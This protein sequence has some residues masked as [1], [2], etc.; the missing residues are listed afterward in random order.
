MAEIMLL[1]AKS[2]LGKIAS[3]TGDLI[4]S[5]V[6]KEMKAVMSV[7]KDVEN[8][9]N[10]LEAICAVLEDADERQYV[11]NAFHIWIRNLKRVVYDIDD[12]LDE[13]AFD[14]LKHRVN[15]SHLSSLL[16][17]I[18]P[19]S[20]LLFSLQ[21]SHKIRDLRENLENIVA[22]RNEFGLTEHL[23]ERSADEDNWSTFNRVPVVNRPDIVGRC[24]AEKEILEK[25]GAVRKYDNLY[26]LPIVGMGGIGKTVLAKL[27]YCDVKHFDVKVWVSVSEKFDMNKIIKGILEYSH[28]R[29]CC[30]VSNNVEMGLR[31]VNKFLSRKKYFL[32][33]DDVWEDKIDEW[34]KLRNILAVG[35]KGS[36]VLVTTRKRQV[37][38]ITKTVDTYYLDCLPN[39]V[40]WD[41]FKQ[42][43][44]EKDEEKR[45]PNLHGIGLSIVE[46]CHGVPTVVKSLGK[47]LRNERDNQE[48]HRIAQM[49]NFIE[50]IHQ[51]DV[52][53]LKTLEISYHK[54][55]SHLKLCFAYLSLCFKGTDLKTNYVSY[56]WS[57]LGLLPQNEDIEL[58]GY[59]YFMKLV[60]DS[61]LLEPSS[62]SIGNY[63]EC[64]MHGIWHDLAVNILGE[65]LAIVNFDKLAVTEFTRHIVWELSFDSFKDKIFP[66][67]LRIARKART[68]R[69]GYNMKTCISK[70]F[71][72]EII[73]NFRFL[74]LLD[75]RTLW[76]E[77]LPKSIGNLKHLRF[78][79]ISENPYIKSLPNTICKLLN[80]E[81][82]HVSYCEKLQKL[83]KDIYQLQSLK[84][85]SMTTC[86]VSLGT[87][88]IE[89]SFL[90][91]LTLRSC[92]GLTSMWDDDNV[93]H[94][95]SL[96]TLNII[97]CPKLTCLPNWFTSLKEITISDCPNMS[98][99]PATFRHLT[100][101]KR[102]YIERC[103]LLSTRYNAQ[104]GHDY[105]L[106]R[107]IPELWITW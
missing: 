63:C 53:V 99:L 79:D 37:A 106:V 62:H 54:L 10:K 51:H 26:V 13:V 74:R 70:S 67:E 28:I 3:F 58:M 60:S 29:S 83:P 30:S 27:V 76:F 72:E 49:D 101:L 6:T 39:D 7:K 21:L 85:L 24:I 59:S 16:R 17:Y 42:L 91:S 31:Q 86:Q 14:A 5:S 100:S 81:A 15:G 45:Y 66:Q 33:L 95:N 97:D 87:R 88:F 36:V 9:G 98:C 41:I 77:D 61:L 56:M 104:D 65:E 38:S 34:R 46:K 32:V 4:I 8:I 89:L 96:R 71:L 22:N 40:C 103:S 25:I 105:S 55:P 78:L 52:K 69:F 93:R 20:N 11:N 82:F 19:S 50:L 84:K 90:Q 48:W 68:F 80:L 64:K 107:H 44:F 102:L 94:L 92:K 35:K 43:A 2:T 57:A 12:L 23:V 73:S 75:L 47:I 18:S 1:I